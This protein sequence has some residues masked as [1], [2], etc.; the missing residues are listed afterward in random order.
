MMKHKFNAKI[1]EV[2]DIKFGSKKEA[3]Y[4]CQLQL[5][6]TTGEVLQFLRQVP[7]HLPGGVVYRLDF[8]VFWANGDITLVE[9]KGYKTDMYILKKKMVE[10]LYYP[11]KIIEV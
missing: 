6:K 10:D 9:V 5:L 3:K 8:M 4:Y 7:F 2:D 1:T 11:F